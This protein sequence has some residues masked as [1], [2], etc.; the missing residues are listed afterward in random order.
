MAILL[1]V[2]VVGAMIL[3]AVSVFNEIAFPMLT[4]K[5]WFPSFRKQT[6]LDLVELKIDKERYRQDVEL[7]SLKLDKGDNADNR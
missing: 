4:G 6:E 7:L 2:L 1:E 3:L 5:P